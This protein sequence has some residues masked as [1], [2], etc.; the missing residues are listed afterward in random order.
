MLVSGLTDLK[1]TTS[2]LLTKGKTYYFQVM[3]RN[4]VG[5]SLPSVTRPILVAQLPDAPK[6]VA[7]LA[8]GTD[9]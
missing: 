2:V 3:A 9:I 7:T 4:S 6:D 1:H 8:I 5:L